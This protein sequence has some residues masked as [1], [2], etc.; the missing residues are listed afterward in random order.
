[1]IWTFILPRQG[2]VLLPYRKHD[3]NI[4]TATTRTCFVVIQKTWYEHL[5]CHDKDL[6][7]Y[8]TKLFPV[9]I[10]FLNK[11]RSI[12]LVLSCRLCG[13][14]QYDIIGKKLRLKRSQ[15]SG[16]LS[17]QEAVVQELFVFQRYSVRYVFGMLATS[18]LIY[19][20]TLILEIQSQS[21][22]CL[23]STDDCC[24]ETQY[25]ATCYRLH[26]GQWVGLF[27]Y[28][29]TQWNKVY[30]IETSYKTLSVLSA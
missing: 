27:D 2:P 12:P 14:K 25:Y 11:V 16:K 18:I 5:H 15:Y 6:F 1:M 17:N 22:S 26:Q 20:A 21:A 4:H 24:E 23:E 3:M 30:Q 29:I 8:H 19:L 28:S 10:Q 9:V 13:M 7:C